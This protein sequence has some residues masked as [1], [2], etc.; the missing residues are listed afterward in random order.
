MPTHRG[1]AAGASK[2]AQEVAQ[3]N[4]RDKK[5][6]RKHLASGHYVTRQLE[7]TLRP[8]HG[9]FN[10]PAGQ[11]SHLGYLLALER[12]DHGLESMPIRCKAR[13]NGLT[14]DLSN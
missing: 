9:P 2:V 8:P 1:H 12:W 3:A 6:T 4:G 5:L 11:G 13:G 7:A 14:C 10:A